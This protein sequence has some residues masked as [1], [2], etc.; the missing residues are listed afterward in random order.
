MKQ[1]SLVTNLAETI[2]SPTVGY[3]PAKSGKNRA[4]RTISSDLY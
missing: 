4:K 2:L 3:E 1:E